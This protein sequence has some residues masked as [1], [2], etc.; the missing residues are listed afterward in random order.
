MN[1]Y[2]PSGYVDIEKIVN[3]KYPFIFV[4]GGRGTG[5]T[6]GACK[7]LMEH[8][9]IKFMYLRRIQQE[10]DAIGNP[11]FSPF[12][13]VLEDHPELPPITLA[14]IPGVKNIRG[15]YHGSL[16][17]A[18]VLMPEGEAIGY[19]GAL[20][21]ISSIRG[22]SGEQIELVL[23]DEFIPEKNARAIK[24]EGDA[25]L[26]CYETINR[27]RE[28]KGKPPLKI[29][30]LTNANKLASPIFTALGITEQV[31]SMTRRGKECSFLDSRGIALIKLKNSPISSRK[32]QTALYRAAASEDFRRM[33]L[34]NDFDTSTYMYIHPEPLEEY[35]II[36][37]YEDIYIYRHKSESK[38]Y[39]CRHCSGKPKKVYKDELFSRKSMRRDLALLYDAWLKGN[40]SFQ[41]YYTKMILTDSLC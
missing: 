26:N 32:A 4:L 28:L 10:A 12:H 30:S 37:Q 14:P 2:L 3:L 25:F 29:I 1:F 34:Q 11:E 5:K 8:P 27:N 15:V 13:P 19:V 22:F 41:D 18:G 6:Y 16:N 17:D 9:E 21:T 20:N 7:Y 38:Y 39:V 35:R 33:A 24:A 23:Y 36:A 31:D 40:I